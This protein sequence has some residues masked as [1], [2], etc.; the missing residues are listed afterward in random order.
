[1]FELNYKK[2]KNETNNAEELVEKVE[3]PF[4]I[5]WANRLFFQSKGADA[6]AAAHS[7]INTAQANVIDAKEYLTNILRTGERWFS[8]KSE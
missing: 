3:K 1:M 4:V 8:Q 5:S 6:G 7:I 2:G